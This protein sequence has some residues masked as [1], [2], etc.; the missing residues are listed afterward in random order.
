MSLARGE[1]CIGLDANSPND[2]NFSLVFNT[3]LSGV[4]EPSTFLLLSAGIGLMSARRLA[5]RRTP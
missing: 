5:K 4:P 1:Y 2:P 3:P